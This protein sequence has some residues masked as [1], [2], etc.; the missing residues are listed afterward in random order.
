M[1]PGVLNLSAV[2]LVAVLGF[3]CDQKPLDSLPPP[4]VPRAAA[5]QP[6][7]VRQTVSIELGGNNK[8]NGLGL[9]A[10]N[11][12]VTLHATMEGVECRYI[13][14][15]PGKSAY[16]YFAIDPAFKW[17]DTM[18]VV[19]AVEYFDSKQ[20]YFLLQYDGSE[21]D[22][23]L[24]AAYVTV[25]EAEVFTGTGRWK[26]RYFLAKDARFRNAQNARSDFRLELHGPELFV[27]RV[28]V[29][30]LDVP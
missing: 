30:R 5:P 11:D 27:H 6:P 8:E 2:P 1:Q 24:A 16:F 7:A 17:A 21:S 28:S 26:E 22:S 3:G 18:D 23:S 12:G 19:V 15:A 10:N 9:R 4:P 20:G 25:N 29:I 13:E 14:R